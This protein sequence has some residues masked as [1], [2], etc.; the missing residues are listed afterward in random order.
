[1]PVADPAMINLVSCTAMT[2]LALGECPL[3]LIIAALETVK[4]SQVERMCLRVREARTVD[5]TKLH[6]LLAGPSL[7]KLAYLSVRYCPVHTTNV[8]ETQ[9]ILRLLQP[10]KERI[11]FCWEGPLLS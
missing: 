1:M 8:K 7:S 4:G 10:M 6:G 3:S 11:N 9:R 5:W 2:S